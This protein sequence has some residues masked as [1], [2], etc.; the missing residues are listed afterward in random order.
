MS[1]PV[2]C[3]LQLVHC[4]I[5]PANVLLKS[6]LTDIRGFTTKLCDFGLTRMRQ[7]EVSAVCWVGWVG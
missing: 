4:D 5:K 6:C 3:S 1:L 7:E 2:T